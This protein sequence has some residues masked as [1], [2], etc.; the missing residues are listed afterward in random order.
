M[1]LRE[2]ELEGPD[3]VWA[4]LGLSLDLVLDLLF[5]PKEKGIDLTLLGLQ[6]HPVQKQLYVYVVPC[7]REVVG[8]CKLEKI[9][10]RCPFDPKLLL[11]LS[12]R[13]FV[14]VCVF[15]AYNPA[16]RQVDIARTIIFLHRT[17]LHDKL[18]S[19]VDYENR[20]TPMPQILLTLHSY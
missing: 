8:V 9:L 12:L 13:A 3:S 6:L 11:Y 10:W 2:E 5:R 7:T 20:S 14:D 16:C 18:S 15:H 1:P 17:L 4:D 19:P